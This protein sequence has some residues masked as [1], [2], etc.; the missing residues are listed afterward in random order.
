MHYYQFNIGDYR[1]DTA[2]LKPIEHYI[3]RTLIDWYYLDEN[4][5]SLKTDLVIRRLSLG[6]DNEENLLNVLS[7][8]FKKMSDGWHHLRIDSE[9]VSYHANVLK[10]K[11]N[12]KLGG[13]P[14]KTQSVILDNPIESEIKPNQ[15]LITNNHKPVKNN[16]TNLLEFNDFWK[17]YPKKVGKDKAITAWGK[18]KPPLI[19]VLEALQWQIISDQWKSGYIPNPATYINDGRWQ[20]EP[21]IKK[22]QSKSFKEDTMAAAR[23]IFTNSSGIPYYQAKEIEIKN[24]E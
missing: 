9:I 3:Y 1:K 19:E 16:N 21:Q 11:A 12:G 8:F 7:D 6:S 20:D 18:K 10:N 5:I 17:A 15:E 13:R 14:R 24:D 4:P 2:H 22:P 23:S